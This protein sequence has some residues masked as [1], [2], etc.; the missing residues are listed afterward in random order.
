MAAGNGIERVR[1]WARQGMETSE[2]SPTVIG[3]GSGLNAT[4]FMVGKANVFS[5]LK[6]TTMQPD[7]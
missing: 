1:Y 2:T 3:T 7:V 6:N 4:V 5:K